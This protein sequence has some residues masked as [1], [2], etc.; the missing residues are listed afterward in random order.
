[1]VKRIDNF[2]EVPANTEHELTYEFT[3]DNKMR[4]GRAFFDASGNEFDRRPGTEATFAV[5]ASHDPPQ[6]TF[7]MPADLGIARRKEG[8]I[9]IEDRL[10]Y[11]AIAQ[12]GMARPSKFRP[13]KNDFRYL[14][15]FSKTPPYANNN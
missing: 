11:V 7:L 15:I 1:M 13:D 5:D 3:A 4:L 6:L 10:L 8:I 2:E 9:K 14:R 12:P